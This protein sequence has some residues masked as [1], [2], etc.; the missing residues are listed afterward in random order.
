MVI[1][2]LVKHFTKTHIVQ[3]SAPFA[4]RR[5]GIETTVKYASAGWLH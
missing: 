3:H 1:A 2:R 4:V 5:E